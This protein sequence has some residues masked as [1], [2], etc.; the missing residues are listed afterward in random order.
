MTSFI[1]YQIPAGFE[2]SSGYCRQRP[3]DLKLFDCLFNYPTGVK[4]TLYNI[5]FS[6]SKDGVNG[7]LS[8]PIDYTR[9]QTMARRSL[10]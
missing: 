7:Y 4:T 10:K 1:R 9:S 8:V 6:Y 2:P 5:Q 3:T